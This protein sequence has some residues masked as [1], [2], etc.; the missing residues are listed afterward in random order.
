MNLTHFKSYTKQDVLSFVKIRRFET[1]LGERVQVLNDP[2][3]IVDSLKN[4]TARYVVIGIPEDIG[5]QA[6]YGTAGTSTAWLSFLQSFLN[7]QS[8]DFLEG[9]EV[10]VIGHFD[11]GD[12]QFVIDKNAHTEEEKIEAYRHAVNAIDEEVEGLVKQITANNKIPI[13]I[14]GGHNNAYP[15][16]KGSAKGLLQAQKISLAQ[17]NCVNLD[18]HTDYRP[19]EGRHSGNAFRYAEE[20]NFLQK[21]C[22]VG[23]HE[24]YLPQNVW[25]DIVNNPFIDCITFEDIFIH[26][27]RSFRQAVSHAIEFTEDNYA[28]IELD[29]DSVEDVLSSACSPSGVSVLNARQYVNLCAAHVK[30]AYLHICEGATRLNNGKTNDSTGKLIS[31]LVSDFIKMHEV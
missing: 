26:E 8:N 9:G 29:L 27:K 18:A 2:S 23:I 16:I 25:V 19:Q 24:N 12:I 15:I 5:I 3:A 11:F 28:G 30:A 17:I 21:Y 13:V 20:D 4:L 7:I 22:I 31:Y 10:A 14:G 1:K 6:N